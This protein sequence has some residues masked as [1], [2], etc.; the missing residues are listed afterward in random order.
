MKNQIKIIVLAVIFL[1]FVL[2]G[3]FIIEEKFSY[4]T[5]MKS[6]NNGI[7]IDDKSIAFKQPSIVE[8]CEYMY[9]FNAYPGPE[10]IIFF[11]L[12]DPGEV[13]Y[14]CLN[15]SN[16]I[17]SS[18][19]FGCDGIWYFTVENGILYC[20]D[21][22]TC[23]MWLIGGGGVDILDIAYNPKNHKMYGSSEDNHLYKID[24]FTG[25]QE[26]IGPFGGDV[27]SMVWMSFNGDGVLY[28]W[29]QLGNL[30]TI[31]T[32]TGE[33]TPYP[34]GFPI[35]YLTDGDFCRETNLLYITAYT[36]TGQLYVL[37][38]DTGEYTLIGNI[39]YGIEVTCCMIPNNCTW[40]P[41]PPET[42]T[43]SGPD[44]GVINQDY[45]FT[46]VSSDPNWDDIYYYIDWG[47]NSTSGWVG[48]YSNGEE[49]TINHTWSEKG[50]YEIKAKAKDIYGLTSEW[51]D[52]FLIDIL[53][54]A[55]LKIDSIKG[56]LFRISTQINNIGGLEA[57]DVNWKI[58]LDGGAFIGKETTGV[59]NIPA[60]G[61]VT[62]N[63]NFIF[64]L[65]PTKLT[66]TA[67]IPESFVTES[68]G[69]FVIL[70]YVHVKIGG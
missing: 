12:A 32:E 59:T 52:I 16:F 54:L 66:I 48:P 55:E 34:I 70:I 64:G 35:H 3:C 31:D 37:D 47:D 18:N 33:A 40:I 8:D 69:G 27:M 46:V 11:P 51:S 25:E 43:I 30:Y 56:G 9:G 17:S 24:Q 41:L 67:D 5:A 1:A 28:G 22:F 49:V 44:T 50:L 21:I 19:T 65:G 42:P 62:I 26:Q 60:G 14:L 61:N 15:L 45:N 57:I 29:D 39:G 58:T 4:V 68:R 13:N 23:E 2:N 20:L 36:T 7:L 63:S 10:G 53:G 38:L 6:T